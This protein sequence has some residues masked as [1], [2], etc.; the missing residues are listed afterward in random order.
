MIPRCFLFFVFI[1]HEIV[2]FLNPLYILLQLFSCPIKDVMVN[3]ILGLV[4][5][6][7]L[8]LRWVLTHHVGFQ[9]KI[10][11]PQPP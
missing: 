11:L 9:L 5:N 2:V 3:R 7:V 10:L 6:F 8:F 1:I 4:E